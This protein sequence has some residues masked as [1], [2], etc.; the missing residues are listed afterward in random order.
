MD[1][2]I[3]LKA[4]AGLRLAVG[5]IS[6]VAPEPRRQALRPRPGRQPAGRLP[7]PAVRRPRRRA[8]RRHAAGAA[9][10]AATTGSSSG[11]CATRPTP[12]RRSWAGA[13]ATC[14][15]RPPR[16][17]PRRAIAATALGVIRACATDAARLHLPA[18]DPAPRRVARA[19]RRRRSPSTAALIGDVAT[20]SV[21]RREAIREITVEV[22][23]KAARRAARRRA[24]RARRRDGHLVPRPRVHRAR[25]RQARRRRRRARSAPTRTCATSTRRA[26]RGCRSAIAEHPRARARAS[27]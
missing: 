25:R 23:D 14:R 17:S 24:R 15:P 11:S 13:R 21:A 1:R 26:S 27:R 2:D 6:Y 19:G 9:E 8:R 12:A 5:V 18:A 22:R 7:R 3:A 10:G 16:W 20:I 4:L